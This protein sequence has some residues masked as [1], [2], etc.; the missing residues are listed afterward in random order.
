MLT[1]PSSITSHSPQWSAWRSTFAGATGEVVEEEEDDDD[2]E[3]GDDNV[4][5][6]SDK[7]DGDGDGGGGALT[8]V[9]MS[10]R[11]DFKA[12]AKAVSCGAFRDAS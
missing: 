12:S 8:L 7:D 5:D 11:R 3:E 1:F 6:D 4:N 10:P 2:D 9:P